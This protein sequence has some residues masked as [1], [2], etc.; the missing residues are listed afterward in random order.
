MWSVNKIVST[1]K[2]LDDALI[3]ALSRVT[4]FKGLS[5]TQLIWVISATSR[6]VV[7]ADKCF[8]ESGDVT[9]VLFILISGGVTIEKATKDG[10][11]S[12][13]EISP[14]QTFAEL[15]FVDSRP[16]TTRARAASKSLALSLH[17]YRLTSTHDVAMIL[18]RNIAAMQSQRLRKLNEQN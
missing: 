3:G 18:Y 14:G 5:R 11:R 6:V 10:L 8:Y 17:K 16:H 15:A 1:P 4:L 7:D 2:V 9:D 13:S 12:I